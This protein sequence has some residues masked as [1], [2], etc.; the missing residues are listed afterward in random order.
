MVCRTKQ[1]RKGFALIIAM[2][3]VCI[4]GTL[5]ACFSNMSNVNVQI[6]HN[7]QTANGALAGA[8]SG[9]D[10]I[11][12]LFGNIT[13]SSSV[14]PGD[15]LSRVDINLRQNLADAG[16]SYIIDDDKYEYDGSTIAIQDV[17]LDSQN[18]Q[19]FNVVIQQVSDD[20]VQVDVS[21]SSDQITRTIRTNF[22]FT[23]SISPLLDYG[24]ASR[25]PLHMNGNAKLR[26]INSSSEADVY[27][28]SFDNNE[29]LTMTGNSRIDGDVSVAN[30]DGYAVV[31]GNS[32]IGGEGGQAAIDNHVHI[33]TDVPEFP[34][35]DISPFEQYIQNIIDGGTSTNGNKTFQN[36]RIIS[37]ANPTFN[38]NIT[39]NGIIFVESPNIVFFSGNVT[40]VGIIVAEGDAE[41]PDPGDSISFTGNLFTYDCS[42]LPASA[43]FDGLRDM[44]HSFL[45]APGFNLS[46]G[47][48][49]HTIGGVIAGNGISF[50]GNAGGTIGGTVLN[51]SDEA[52]SLGGNTTLDFSLPQAGESPTGFLDNTTLEFN[53]E[54][55]A[56]IVM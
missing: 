35:P 42:Y 43:D 11:R 46:F 10:V 37:G 53:A 2:I 17:I 51:Y 9:L 22:E 20:V 38:G 12:F 8:Q 56:E 16:M 1:K 54:S 39:I 52:M 21:G 25:G 45:L 34:I 15:R 18:N 30:Q 28:E 40:I 50:S 32:T 55:Y 6:S 27:I 26:G 29:A 36:I 14:A 31:S 4:F 24:V 49:F 19:N 44:E 33:G 13:V 41:F 3:F 48:N 5:L 47:G 23:S 7:E